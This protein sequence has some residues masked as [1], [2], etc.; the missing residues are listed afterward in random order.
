MASPA[1]SSKHSTPAKMPGFV[2][3]QLCELVDEPPEGPSWVHE[4]LRANLAMRAGVDLV[5]ISN[6]AIT[7]Y[8]TDRNVRPQFVQD[9]Q[10]LYSTA[11]KTAW[12]A[13]VQFLLYA[14]GTFV[15]SHGGTL[16]LGVV[17]DSTLNETNDHVAA[18]TEEFLCVAQVG[19]SARE[20]AVALGVDGVTG[21]CP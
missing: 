17:R 3:P 5:S 15:V 13:T 14:A 20:V 1:K 7:G 18:W 10:P 16:D 4:A 19:A 8:F 21:C 9:Y 2:V 12:P 6:A 11:P